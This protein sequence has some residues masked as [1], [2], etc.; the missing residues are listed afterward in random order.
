MITNT[1]YTEKDIK[2]GLKENSTN[3]KGMFEETIKDLVGYTKKPFLNLKS[4]RR[5]YLKYYQDPTEITFI[6]NVFCKHY[7]VWEKIKACKSFSERIKSIQSEAEVRRLRDNLLQISEIAKDESNK[8]RFSALKY[9]CDNNFRNTTV[10]SKRGRPSKE[11][12]EGAK[13]QILAEDTELTEALER[14]MVNG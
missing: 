2:E 6:D 7:E 8:A 14:L 11:E 3:V 13:K 5:L 9:L 10:D 12:L 1:E 4:L